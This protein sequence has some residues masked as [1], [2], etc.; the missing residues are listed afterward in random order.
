MSGARFRLTGRVQGV[1][2]RAHAQQQARE[3]QLS[4]YAR[5]LDDGSV[6]IEAHG[7]D[8]ALQSFAAWLAHGPA[9]ARVEQVIR[10]A[11]ETS[12]TTDGFRIH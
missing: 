11:C 3:L 12:P 1:G 5:N 10:S 4:G 7:G 6:E 8:D 2:F 9:H